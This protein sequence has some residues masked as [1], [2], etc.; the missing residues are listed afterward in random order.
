MLLSEVQVNMT[1]KQ[2]WLEQAT[3]KECGA[4]WT[5]D[6]QPPTECIFK[7]ETRK[8]ESCGYPTRHAIVYIQEAAGFLHGDVA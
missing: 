5:R 7:I 2:H 8:C 3:C 6:V 1:Q 4:T